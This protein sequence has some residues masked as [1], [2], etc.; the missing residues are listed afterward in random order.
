MAF[1]QIDSFRDFTRAPLAL[2]KF[3]GF[4]LYR[5]QLLVVGVNAMLAM[6]APRQAEQFVAL[7]HAVLVQ[8]APD[9]H[10]GE[11]YL[12]CSILG[13]SQYDGDRYAGKLR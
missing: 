6:P 10:V 12:T 7:A 8:V 13:S 11:H 3:I 2:R 9:A 1:I 5:R 4:L